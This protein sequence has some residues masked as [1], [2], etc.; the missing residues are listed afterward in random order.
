M[1][2]AQD[3]HCRTGEFLAPYPWGPWGWNACLARVAGLTVPE[4]SRLV[5]TSARWVH[6]HV[7]AIGRL[8]L[9]LF[10]W[11]ALGYVS[12]V[13]ATPRAEPTSPS[14][15]RLSARASAG[16]A[17]S[18]GKS[19]AAGSSLRAGAT[20]LPFPVPLLL[21]VGV[22]PRPP[23][24]VGKANGDFSLVP[25]IC[26]FPVPRIRMG[27]VPSSPRDPPLPSW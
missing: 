1:A 14:M 15:L 20:Y 9:A 7:M 25:H 13:L 3:T 11:V 4:G 8:L 21:P 23:S 17:A 12:P 27:A 5:P 16:V 18:T 2:G 24:S 6:N 19:P 22:T 10:F 26:P